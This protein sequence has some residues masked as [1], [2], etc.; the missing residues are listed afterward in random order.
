MNI[1]N[2]IPTA[3][4]APIAAK[5]SAKKPEILLGGGIALVIGGAVMACKTTWCKLPSR[6]DEKDEKIK[7]W[8]LGE[9][10]EASLAQV[11]TQA[12]LAMSGKIAID[13]APSL[14]MISGGIAMIIGGHNLLRTRL[15]AL[16]AAYATLEQAHESYRQRVIEEHGA[17]TDKKYRLGIFDEVTEETV[18][19]KS[20]KEKV[21]KRVTEAVHADGTEYSMYARYFDQFN[22]N[23]HVLDQQA[24]YDFLLR[25][26][27]QLNER[28]QREGYLFL[29]TVYKELGFKEVPEG[30]L[31]GW[32]LDG[33]DGYVDFGLFE[34]RNAAARDSVNYNGKETCFI[35]DFNVDG[36]M[37]NRI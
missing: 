7:D 5:I 13:Y 30:Q 8:V 37:W 14:V 24:N 25:M 4:L 35:L 28:L 32:T 23:E 26:Q 21:K 27:N 11:K 3:K 29:N 33:G 31:V 15:A 9:D 16:G 17:E 36:I 10:D 20:G 12:Y 2:K 34:A 22:S 19:T 18:I 1:L 6:I